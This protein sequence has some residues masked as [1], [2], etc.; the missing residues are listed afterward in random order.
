M[1][2]SLQL[3][4][5]KSF[6]ER[7]KFDF[8]EGISAV[9]GP[10]GS[11]KSNI[12]DAVRWILGEQSAKSLRGGEMTDV[13]FNGSSTR[14]SLGLAEVSMTF[15]NQKQVLNTD[16]AEVEITRRVYRDGEGEYLINGQLARLKDIKDL[17]LGSGAGNG[18]YGII[19]QG[20]VD[21]LLSASTR[22]RRMVF[23]EAA[24]ISRFKAKK[25][26]TLRKLERVD[27][28]LTR[29]ND[30]LNELE[31]QLRTLKLQ[32]AKAERHQ[33]YTARL[34]ELRV[35]LATREV[36]QLNRQ[37]AEVE[38]ALAES[39]AGLDDVT[40]RTESG[41]A[42]L[43]KLDW[44]VSRTVE[45]IRHHE[46]KLAEAKQA[47]S[48]YETIANNERSNADTANA[49][50]LRLLKQ[51]YELA[52]R[53]KKHEAD[54]AAISEQLAHATE[55]AS[56][57]NRQVE[58]LAGQLNQ[59]QK[60]VAELQKRQQADR[61][62]QFEVVSRSARFHSDADRFRSFVDRLTRDLERKQQEAEEANN[63]LNS[64]S[65]ALDELSRSDADIQQQ[66][67][68][69]KHRLHELNGERS[70]M[71]AEADKLHAQLEELREARS[72]CR[73]RAEVLENLEQS[74]EG[75]DGG[76]RELL[77]RWHQGEAV[78]KD[79]LAGVV[80]DL[81]SVSHEDAPLIDL[82]LGETAQRFVLWNADDL[83]EVLDALGELPGRVGL[84]PLVSAR[85]TSPPAS[86]LAGS[87]CIF[88]FQV[89]RCDDPK[90][91]SLP[92]RV[93]GSTIITP[94]LITAQAWSAQFPQFRFLTRDGELL[95][96]DGSLSIGGSQTSTGI[97]SRK[98]ELR[99]LRSRIEALDQEIASIESAQNDLRTRAFG[100]NSPIQDLETE[101]ETLSST[102]GSLR[103]Q[104]LEQRQMLRQLEESIQL[105]K[106]ECGILEIDHS[107]ATA[108][109][110]AAIRHA[111][112][113]DREAT[114]L[115]ERLDQYLALL[116]QAEAD[117][118]AV[119]DRL[120]AAKVEMGRWNEQ[121]AG[122]QSRRDSLEAERKQRVI[123]G[124][125]MQSS[126]RQLTRRQR[127]SLLTCMRSLASAASAYAEKDN[128]QGQ[129]HKL[130]QYL[131]EVRASREA[132]DSDLRQSR[133]T[134]NARREVAHA[135]ELAAQECRAKRDA[136]AR[137]LLED[138]DI[139]LS[140]VSADDQPAQE[141]TDLGQAE[142]EIGE[143]RRKLE[144]LGSV[145]L[146]ALTE[147]R[148]LEARH[149]ELKTQ[150][151]DLCDARNKLQTI[152][153]QI[154]TDSRRLF[155]ET[156]EAVRT[157]FQE[158]FRK[159]FGGGMADIVLEDPNDI[160]ETGIEI[161]ARPP[162][163]ELRK[164]SLL[165]GGEKALTAVALLLAVFRSRP[166]PFCILDEVD[167]AM[168]EANTQ[169]L[170]LLLKEF[171]DQSQF[172]VITHKKR[173]MAVAD[174]LYG[175]TM[176]ESGVSKLVAV[177]FEDYEEPE[178]TGEADDSNRAAA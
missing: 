46:A 97:V 38:S 166:A 165:S 60:H 82:A 174:V 163:K 35:A 114:E 110:D 120:T 13:I 42:E 21:A 83:Q 113:A 90:L 101:I 103:D 7:T 28:D 74:H 128:R 169:R 91:A 93:L 26:E 81:I 58:E 94:D 1:L 56:Q 123:D 3:V 29:V 109:R 5:F 44:E 158:L 65:R 150:H 32:A 168:D 100:F 68:Q 116:S 63:R 52:L 99:E 104:I 161:T 31:N 157:R 155:G 118:Q 115:R 140:Q 61:D 138:Y 89:V 4:G 53:L 16:A 133:E 152:I 49:E 136:V 40:T 147:L 105:T 79:K 170:A 47:I 111:E 66:L 107:R 25:V 137:R 177:R 12:V 62:L 106:Q 121:L 71:L 51:Q 145:N 108:D 141:T 48:T 125:N 154:N 39:R 75:F 92:E 162:G 37:L 149:D 59:G 17:F 10:N 167:A 8:S 73:G 11:G 19:E 54:I 15:N 144:R 122:M 84:L 57:A 130:A 175:V 172:I 95:E 78:L 148:E 127:E 156:L 119:Q 36:S 88:A 124:V 14:K 27:G 67:S 24:G 139:D 80:A 96:P 70:R 164:L 20:R 131:S 134:W 23:E 176:Q 76:V 87:D 18:A 85:P 143:L 135:H 132:W 9:V 178:Q 117:K 22:D 86:L 45:S 151:V 2:K 142:Q 77:A 102:A 33:E 173:T 153:D 72:A 160:L 159:L 69:A 146:E 34:K 41:E 6:A 50:R 98:S 129:I 55:S 30:I 112:E 64:K 126:I 171:S 43:R